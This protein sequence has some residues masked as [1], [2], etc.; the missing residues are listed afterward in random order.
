MHPSRAKC[1]STVFHKPK[2]LFFIIRFHLYG[3]F[4]L[5]T[6]VPASEH[7]CVD[8]GMAGDSLG[9]ERDESS[10]AQLGGSVDWEVVPTGRL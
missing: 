4:S 1:I 3:R 9:C 2:L 6:D 10:S 8:L 7:M 5:Q